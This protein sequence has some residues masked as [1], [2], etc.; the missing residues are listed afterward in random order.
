MVIHELTTNAMK[1]GALSGSEGQVEVEWHYRGG[2]TLHLRWKERGG[3]R[4]R[5]PEGK[6]FGSRLIEQA[7]T[8]ELGGHVE[9]TYEVGG[10]TAGSPSPWNTDLRRWRSPV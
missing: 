3:P 8:S 10:C 5:A 2:E 6:G 9:T 4:V 7:I 1:Y